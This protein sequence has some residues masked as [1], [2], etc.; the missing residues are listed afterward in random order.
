MSYDRADYDLAK[1]TV[2]IAFFVAWAMLSGLAGQL[3]LEDDQEL[4]AGLRQREITPGYFFTVACD[5]KFVEEDLNDAG[6]RFVC[7]YYLHHRKRAGY[8]EDYARVL[9][10]EYGEPESVVDCWENYDRVAPVIT[11]RYE[12]WKNGTK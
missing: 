8:Y 9:L 5:C 1:D 7:D 12:Q 11:G 3:H 2:R 6:N 10:S 4:L